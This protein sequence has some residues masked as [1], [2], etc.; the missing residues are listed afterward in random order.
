MKD[1]AREIK[2]EIIGDA[3]GGYGGNQIANCRKR[4]N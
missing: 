1:Y 2:L 4:S 3:I